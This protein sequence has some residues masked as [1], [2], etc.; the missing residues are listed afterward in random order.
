MVG[1]VANFKEYRIITTTEF[2]GQQRVEVAEVMENI[3][4]SGVRAAY[5]SK[6]AQ[7]AVGVQT[8]LELLITLPEIMKAEETPHETAA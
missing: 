2:Y 3:P 5:I 4:K 7:Q 1:A 6:I 8:I